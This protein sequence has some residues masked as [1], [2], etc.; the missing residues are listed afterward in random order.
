MVMVIEATEGYG[1]VSVDCVLDVPAL[2]CLFLS[3]PLTL[4]VSVP[5]LLVYL[6]PTV[7]MVLLSLVSLLC[8]A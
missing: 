5:D 8:A 2:L 7:C 1:A 6:T 4:S 3:L